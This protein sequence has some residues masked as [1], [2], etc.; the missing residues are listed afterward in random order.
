MQLH[1]QLHMQLPND[2]TIVVPAFLICANGACLV[3]SQLVLHCRPHRC[4]V[5]NCHGDALGREDQEQPCWIED[6]YRFWLPG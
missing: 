3:E 6:G 5:G 2:C 4:H 1:M